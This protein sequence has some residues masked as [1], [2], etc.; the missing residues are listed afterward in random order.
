MLLGKTPG[1]LVKQLFVAAT[2]C[3]I[4]A[5]NYLV[6]TVLQSYQGFFLLFFCRALISRFLRHLTGLDFSGWWVYLHL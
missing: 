6:L 2:D 5:Q 3:P 1:L 4:G